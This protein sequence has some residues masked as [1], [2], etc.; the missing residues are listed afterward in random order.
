MN[1][2]TSSNPGGTDAPRLIAIPH[3]EKLYSACFRTFQDCMSVS[4]PLVVS[5]VNTIFGTHHDPASQVIFEDGAFQVV[6]G[7]CLQILPICILDTKDGV[8]TPVRYC[9]GFQPYLDA[10][11]FIELYSAAFCQGWNARVEEGDIIHLRYPYAAIICLW[12]PEDMG[13]MITINATGQN[14]EAC[15][16]FQINIV[17]LFQ[18]TLEENAE[19][20]LPLLPLEILRYQDRLIPTATA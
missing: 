16:P 13:D 6:A 10:E 2:K 19:G 15:Q 17:T 14:G 12:D 9:I 5:V 1:P 7:C 18:R 4:S 11:S 8:E 20:L 3:Q